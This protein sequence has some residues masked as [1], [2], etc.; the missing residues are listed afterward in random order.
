MIC[1]YYR[2]KRLIGYK[3]IDENDPTSG[4]TTVTVKINS[5]PKQLTRSVPVTG[6][7]LVVTIGSIVGLFFG[8][9]I[10]SLYEIV[11]VWIF[12]RF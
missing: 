7:D 3:S 4:I 9:S 5:Q 12:H 8:A 6:L 11:H 2:K 1:R 10:L